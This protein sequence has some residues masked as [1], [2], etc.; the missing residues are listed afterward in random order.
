MILTVGLN[1]LIGSFERVVAS[2]QAEF[3]V[4]DEI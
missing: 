2:W 3:A 4:R 1:Y